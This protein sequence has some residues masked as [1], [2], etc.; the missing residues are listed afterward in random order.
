MG[1]TG[2]RDHTCLQ[3]RHL[4]QLFFKG[5]QI[6]L[7]TGVSLLGFSLLGIALLFIVV[8][9]NVQLFGDGKNRAPH[10]KRYGSNEF[11][12]GFKG[13]LL[14]TCYISF[15]I[16]FNRFLVQEIQ[17]LDQHANPTE[18]MGVFLERRV[19]RVNK[20]IQRIHFLE[21]IRNTLFV[22]GCLPI[23]QW[24]SNLNLSEELDVVQ[25]TLLFVHDSVVFVH[26]F[27]VVVVFSIVLL[28]PISPFG[29]LGFVG[30]RG[31][32]FGNGRAKT[33]KGDTLF[34]R[35]THVVEYQLTFIL[36]V[37]HRLNTNRITVFVY[38]NDAIR[39]DELAI[40][41][42]CIHRLFDTKVLLFDKRFHLALFQNINGLY[43][44]LF[45]IALFLVR[46]FQVK[47]SQGIGDAI[48]FDSDAL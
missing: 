37:L 45:P 7:L 6:H 31:V 3:V 25:F 18:G 20:V 41:I 1:E 47:P 2:R 12:N 33:Q 43:P 8:F 48:G 44:V 13:D 17:C 30:L 19:Q 11:R 40:V 38:G 36:R 29:H 5:R 32:L 24:T 28:H 9:G 14:G 39:P 21:V 4:L 34:G 46:L 23:H 42:Q 27:V 10:R 35:D 16:V 15:P 26:V 22:G